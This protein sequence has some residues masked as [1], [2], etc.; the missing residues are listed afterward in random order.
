MNKNIIATLLLAASTSAVADAQTVVNAYGKDDATSDITLIYSGGL[1]KRA[2]WNKDNLLPYVTHLYA[3]GHREWFYDG[4]LFMEFQ[5]G[6]VVLG[7]SGAGQNPGKK[8]DWLWW[9]DHVMEEGHDLHALDELIGELKQTLGEPRIRHKVIIST[10]A[11]CKDGT[12]GTT[13]W[14]DINWGEIDG[15]KINFTRKAHRTM[16]T[17]WI[18]GLIKE[19][20]DA[21]N[22][23]NIDLAG[24]YWLEES[25][26]SNGDIVPSIN[27]YIRSL[28]MKSYWIPYNLNNAAYKFHWKDTYRFDVAYQQPNYFFYESDGSLPDMSMLTGAIEDSKKYGLGLE[29]EFETEGRSNGMHETSPAMHQRIND[30]IDAFEDYGVWESSGVAHYTGSKG[31]LHMAASADPVNQATIDRLASIVARRQAEFAGVGEAATIGAATF[32]Y[33]GQGEIFITDD[34][35]DAVCYNTAGT[36]IHTGSGRFSCAPGVYIVSNGRGEAVKLLVK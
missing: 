32:A 33:A 9:V 20:F 5:R 30:Y 15:T 21:E 23:Q 17:K 3:D 13:A 8:E 2:V 25:L 6:S 10:P 24:I 18:I 26:Y 19:R 36:A 34:A 27:D 16:A 4:F 12:Q 31:L 14:R 1:A 11:P 7:N 22:F 29:L 35:S 28:G